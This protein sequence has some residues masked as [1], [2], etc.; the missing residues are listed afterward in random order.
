[1][2][3]Y[4]TTHF[5]SIM[6]EPFIERIERNLPIDIDHYELKTLNHYTLNVTF[7]AGF[8]IESTSEDLELELFVPE[9]SVT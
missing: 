6:D 5:D 4:Q 9:F 8:D 3:Y 7:F 2:K 1:M